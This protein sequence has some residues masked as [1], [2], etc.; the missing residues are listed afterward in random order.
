MSET[1]SPE[2]WRCWEKPLLRSYISFNTPLHST[3]N[4][5]IKE[6][7][8]R[9]PWHNLS[10]QNTYLRIFGALGLE[11]TITRSTWEYHVSDSLYLSKPWCYRVRESHKLDLISLFTR[12]FPNKNKK[13]LNISDAEKEI[14]HWQVQSSIMASCFTL[15]INVHSYTHLLLAGTILRS[16]R[17]SL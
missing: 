14:A 3:D 4:L 8:T 10:A 7:I 15:L 6:C 11:H 2:I 9:T 17:S 1:N 16:K 12:N 13:L 5:G